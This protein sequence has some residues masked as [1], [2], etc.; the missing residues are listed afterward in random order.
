MAEKQIY[1][2]IIRRNQQGFTIVEVLIAFSIFAI[3]ILAVTTLAITTINTNASSR[4]L[5]EA[6]ALAEDRLEMLMTLPYENIDN[7][8]IKEAGYDISWTVVED[9]IVEQSKSI[10]VTVTRPGGLKETNVVIRFLIS[11]SST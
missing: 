10:K 4:R 6:T 8:Q 1:K 7:G 9:D 2:N 5:T 11:Q 3:G